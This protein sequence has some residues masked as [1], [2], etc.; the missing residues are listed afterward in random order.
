MR[1]V[2][3]A[4]CSALLVVATADVAFAQ[5]KQKALELYNKGRIQFDLGRWEAAI[6]L[7]QE[8]YEEYPAPALL[9]NIAQAYRHSGDCK[10]A[11]FFYRR[12]LT[13]KPDADNKTEVEGFISDLETN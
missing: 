12:F 13:V 2:H 9:F 3:A 5:D 7:F 1:L 10:N 8:S 6:K 11:L 4:L